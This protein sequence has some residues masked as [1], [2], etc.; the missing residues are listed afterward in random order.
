MATSISRSRLLFIGVLVSLP[1]IAGCVDVQPNPVF[2]AKTGSGGH[3]YTGWDYAAANMQ[4]ITSGTLSIEVDEVANEGLVE[5]TASVMG[6]VYTLKLTNFNHSADDFHSGGIAANF[7]EHGDSGVGNAL[8]PKMH[9]LIATW[10]PADL[11]LNNNPV[12]D[13]YTGN[14]TFDAHLM[15]TDTGVRD[16]ATGKV[17]KAD[18]TTPY[19]PATP[20]DAMIGSDNEAHLVL[21][22]RHTGEDLPADE[23]PWEGQILQP[24]GVTS[25]TFNVKTTEALV[26]I[27]ID[28]GG[29]PQEVGQW[30]V[31]LLNPEGFVVASDTFSNNRP[32]IQ[33]NKTVS[34][35]E[36]GDWTLRV[37]A[38][39]LP[40]DFS[41]T[42]LV[43]YPPKPM[44]YFFWE[45]VEILQK[46]VS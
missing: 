41:A 2:E 43:V 9:L 14:T 30:T 13:P 45:D 21:T 3:Y 35:S 24:L 11:M 15:I 40:A 44:H 20:G 39:T 23:Y 36:P 8:L 6:E 31:E 4:H 34:Y 38:D 10:G 12:R 28:S 17:F 29:D 46:V 7:D 16:D 32:E 5:V 25:T 1:A 37:S 27:T 18:G 19:D 33:I 22:S 42:I 26:D